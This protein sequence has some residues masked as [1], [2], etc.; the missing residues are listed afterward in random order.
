MPLRTG[1]HWWRGRPG[2]HWP[3]LSRTR[4][5]ST[6]W[7][8]FPA[9]ARPRILT[10]RP[11]TTVAISTSSDATGSYTRY[12][13][14]FGANFPDYPKFGVWPDAYYYTANTFGPRSFLGA[15]ACAFDRAAML[16]GSSASMICFQNPPSIASLLPSDLDG[17][18]LPPTGQPHFFVDIADS[19]ALT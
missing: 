5:L 14:D 9:Y 11:R 15:Q 4:S 1:R 6:P 2:Q 19:S 7:L 8:R 13:F 18:P 3:I 10:A 16:A 12:E 17:S